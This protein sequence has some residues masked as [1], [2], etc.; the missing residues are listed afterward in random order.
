MSSP[1]RLKALYSHIAAKVSER[2][3]QSEH[4]FNL[5][6]SRCKKN[7]L[8]TTQELRPLLDKYH[9]FAS[10]QDLQLLWNAHA[11]HNNN[12][13]NDASVVVF[14]MHSFAACVFPEFFAN[15]N[16]FDFDRYEREHNI[17]PLPGANALVPN[18]RA[19]RRWDMH[20]TTTTNNNN[21]NN[22]PN[23]PSQQQQQHQQQRQHP[24]FI[25]NTVNFV[26]TQ[27]HPTMLSPSKRNNNKTPHSHAGAKYSAS[28]MKQQRTAASELKQEEFAQY[29][30]AQR[31]AQQ[32]QH[33][34]P[35]V[36]RTHAPSSGT[37]HFVSAAVQRGQPIDVA[38]PTH[39]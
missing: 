38:S 35:I 23:S 32:Q 13:N 1:N 7:P 24:S 36:I 15:Q 2:S 8:H 28:T 18:Q 3:T 29:R 16:R 19:D 25:D 34:Q 6:I 5:L 22:N 12:N 26:S 30:A 39:R 11:K 4:E 21:N 17:V 33:H 27:P 10:E 31:A 14:D 9:V 37:R 20:R